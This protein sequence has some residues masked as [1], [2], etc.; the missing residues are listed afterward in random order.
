MFYNS[1]KLYTEYKIWDVMHLVKD[2][3][4]KSKYWY[5]VIYSYYVLILQDPRKMCLRIKALFY[6]K[7]I[8]DLTVTFRVVLCL[9]LYFETI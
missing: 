2:C 1:K 4:V 3:V 6:F 8:I 5:D 7:G 9:S